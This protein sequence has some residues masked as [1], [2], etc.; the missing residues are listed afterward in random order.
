VNTDN[1]PA[2]GNYSFSNSTR[3]AGS[4]DWSAVTLVRRTARLA[5]VRNIPGGD[6]IEIYHHDDNGHVATG[7]CQ[8]SK[9]GFGAGAEKDVTL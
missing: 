1:L 6:G 2:A 5:E 7:L 4:C 3:L 9:I 8:R